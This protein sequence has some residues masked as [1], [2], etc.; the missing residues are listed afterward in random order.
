[1]STDPTPAAA[2]RLDTSAESSPAAQT[3][4]EGASSG[5]RARPS[6]KKSL[7]AQVAELP[8]LIIFDFVIAV[9]I[10]TFLVQA[11]FI[12]SL[13][14]LP[15]LEKGDRVLVEKIGYRLGSPE[16]GDVIVFAR[17]V[18][19]PNL[20][21]QP[22]PEDARNFLRELLG[23]PTGREN[24]FI[25]RVVGSGGDVITYSGNPRV[26]E[27]NGERVLEPYLVGGRDRSSAT[28][29]VRDCPGKMPTTE[30]GCRVPDGQVFVMGDNRSNSMD[31]RFVGPIDEADV[32]GRAFVILWPP[33]R[34]SGL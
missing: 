7:W 5:A 25:K 10:K 13:S 33:G 20:P 14:M 29:T 16:R 11:F 27:V 17:T 24:D 22:W 8:L 6:K 30:G 23:L 1:M 21:D 28:I 19:A 2:S 12:P 3:P 18:V 32:V 31:S 34:F 15:T 9:V 4:S 26:L